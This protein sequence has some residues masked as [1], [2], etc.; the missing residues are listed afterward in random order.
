MKGKNK[1][2]LSSSGV[3]CRHGRAKLK[4]GMGVVKNGGAPG[5]L[6]WG[7]KEGRRLVRFLKSKGYRRGTVGRQF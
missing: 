5:W 4:R 7:R 1:A 3:T 6:L 2:E